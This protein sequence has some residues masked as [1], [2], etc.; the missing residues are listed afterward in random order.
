MPVSDTWNKIRTTPAYEGFVTVNRQTYEE[1]SGAVTEWDVIVGRDSAATLAFTPAASHVVLFEQFRVGPEKS[2]L[3]LP[4][5]YLN[6]A[7]QPMEAAL[8]E[9]RE[10][11]GYHSESAFYAGSEWFAANSSRRKHLVIAANASE[12]FATAWDESES[13]HVHLLPTSELMD[14][15]VSGELTDAGLACRGLAALARSNPETEVLADLRGRILQLLTA[16]SAQRLPV[17]ND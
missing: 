13:G 17:G 3:E 11:T 8:R 2:L 5:G 4:G 1:P 14:F 6:D 12:E 16:P 15:L 7:E 9:L 10:E